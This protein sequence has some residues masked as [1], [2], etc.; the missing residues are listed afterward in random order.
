MKWAMVSGTVNKGFK[1]IGFWNEIHTMMEAFEG[2]DLDK[3][4]LEVIQIQKTDREG[5]NLE[6][7]RFVLCQGDVDDGFLFSG[8]FDYIPDWPF[9]EGEYYENTTMHTALTI[10]EFLKK[11]KGSE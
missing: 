9:D 7:G 2:V 10:E 4:N 8:P 5:E 3:N 6:K 1:I 11:I